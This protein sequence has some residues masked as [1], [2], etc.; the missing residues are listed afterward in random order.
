MFYDTPIKFEHIVEYTVSILKAVSVKAIIWEEVM[1]NDK[2]SLSNMY[3]F[4][5]YLNLN[6]I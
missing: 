1:L 4:V 5:F 2:M 3:D 6:I